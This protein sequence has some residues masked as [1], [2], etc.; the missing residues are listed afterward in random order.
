M[1]TPATTS[2]A[3]PTASTRPRSAASLPVLASLYRLFLRAQVSRGRII[4]AA[5][6]GGLSILITY[7]IGRDNPLA[8][9]DTVGFLWLFGIGLAVPIL[10]LVLAS[11]TL[12][13]LVEDETL[14]YLWLRPIRRWPIALAAWSAAFT[15]AI[16]LAV[17][18]MTAAAA[19]GTRG[20]VGVTGWVAVAITLTVMA[21][22]GIFTLLGLL[23]RWALIWGLVYIF[24]WEGFVAL[25]G[26]GAERLAV[27]TYASTVLARMTEVD[28]PRAERALSAG[29]IVP[30]L[31]A[32]VAIA[33]TTWRLDRANVA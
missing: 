11:S 5:A 15:M 18:P 24:I 8:L 20:D 17:V 12:G 9:S 26:A 29:F 7:F 25:A 3:G 13:N 19:L 33:L 22:T 6:L 32:V 14:V 1:T 30:V 23:S 2:P 31:V 21:Y 4:L 16:P 27:G 10:S 28:L